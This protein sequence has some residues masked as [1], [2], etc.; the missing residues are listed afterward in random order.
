[1]SVPLELADP[2]R[3]TSAPV[4]AVAASLHRAASERLAATGSATAEAIDARLDDALVDLARA[5][6]GAALAEAFAGAPAVDVYRHLWR[7]LVLV[8]PRIL[9]TAGLGGVLFAIPVVIVAARTGPGSP[10]HL[11]DALPDAAALVEALRAHEAIAPDG[12]VV[13]STAL[14]GASAL[15]LHALPT[16]WR[17]A[18]RMLEGAEPAPLALAPAPLA[19]EGTQEAAYLRYVVGFGM[20]APHVELLRAAPAR[21]FGG[22]LMRELSQALATEGV[23][24]LALPGVPQRLVAAGVA[25]RAAQRQV[26]LELFVGNALRDLRARYGEPT[27]VLSAHTADDA[28]QGGELRVALSS[29]FAP[30]DAQGFRYPLAPHERVPDAVQAIATLLA[31]CRVSDVRAVPGVQPD[32]DRATG[33]LRFGRP[34]D[35]PASVH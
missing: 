14:A 12:R 7:R 27:A 24:A 25:G 23:T 16:L 5:E 2:R 21:T 6:D 28:P 20:H 10:I 11:P 8:E 13:L 32:R 31:D 30:R 9:S 33:L 35:A 15:E 1:M 29:P 17:H 22:A 3:A 26:A 34:D 4:S 18:R 19:I